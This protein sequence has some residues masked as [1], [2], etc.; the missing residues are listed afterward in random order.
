MWQ[1]LPPSSA[2]EPAVGGLAQAGYR[3]RAGYLVNAGRQAGRYCA[4]GHDLAGAQ[5]YR[6]FIA[7][8]LCPGDATGGGAAAKARN[9]FTIFAEL[10]ERL[11]YREAFTGGRDERGWIETLYQQSALSHAAAGRLSTLFG[12]K[13][14]WYLEVPASAEN[15]VFM[16]EFRQDPQRHPLH[17]P[18]GRIELFSE[19][20]A[21]FAY[22][23]FGPLP[24]WR[25]PAE[26]LGDDRAARYP[27]HLITVQ[28][29]DRLH[30]QLDPAPL[31][32][33]NK[34]A[35]RETLYLHPA[36]AARRGIADGER[37]TCTTIAAVCWRVPG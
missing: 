4:A 6:R 26:W 7:R 28:P 23:D 17:T 32:Q 18:S 3:R 36:D 33:A 27:L 34:T 35:G 37:S 20:I 1:P 15:Y 16:A 2:T 9:D 13:V 31:A 8:S 5:R 21:G 24:E 25:P 30:S 22:E 29:H 10:A 12:G 11:G 19:T 14:I